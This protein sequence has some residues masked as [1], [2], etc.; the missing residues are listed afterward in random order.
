MEERCDVL[1]M[2]QTRTIEEKEAGMLDYHKLQR[3]HCPHN[4][5]TYDFSQIVAYTENG[6]T[7][8]VSI[9][10]NEWG[11]PVVSR[12]HNQLGAAPF[13]ET[14]VEGQLPTITLHF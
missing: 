7:Y 11:H 10:N 4:W 14:I 5:T 8:P 9:G 1:R 12:L 13:T 6:E 3:L 2:V